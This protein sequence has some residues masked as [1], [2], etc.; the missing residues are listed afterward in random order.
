M[1]EREEKLEEGLQR[2]K[3]EQVRHYARLS[4]LL[5]EEKRSLEEAD[6]KEKMFSQP[7]FG[8]IK[9]KENF[10]IEQNKKCKEMK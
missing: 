3:E 1:K 6:I 8:E 7:Q 5:R 4:L 9:E 10:I 2:K